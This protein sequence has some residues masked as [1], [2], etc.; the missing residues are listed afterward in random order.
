[1]NQ[2]FGK[3]KEGFDEG[4]KTEFS[5]SSTVKI[6]KTSATLENSKTSATEF[7]KKKQTKIGRIEMERNR[8]KLIVD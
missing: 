6:S 1:M 5:I 3:I 8:F 7:R 4:K 2:F